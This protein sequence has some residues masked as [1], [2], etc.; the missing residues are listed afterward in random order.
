MSDANGAYSADIP[1]QELTAMDSLTERPRPP[2]VRRRE[3]PQLSCNACRSRNNYSSRGL[4]SSC[5]Y[6]TTGATLSGRPHGSAHVQE[7][8]N[9]LEN[10]VLSLMPSDILPVT[11]DEGP[12]CES[13]SLSGI[14]P[15]RP[16]AASPETQRE[17]S[18]SP[19]DYGS[20][21]IRESG[22]RYVSSEN[23]ATVLDSIAE[24][25][26]HFEHEDETYAHSPDPV[27]LQT[28]VPSP[29]L[30]YGCPS[31]VT[32][33]SILESI[34]PRS[35]VD[36]LVSRYFNDL[37]MATGKAPNLANAPKGSA[38][39]LLTDRRPGA[40][41][42]GKFLREYEEFWKN[43]QAVPIIWVGL[44]FAMMCLFDTFP[45]GFSCSCQYL[46][47]QRELYTTGAGL[48]EPNGDREG[49]PYALESLILYFLVEVFL[50]KEVE[51]GIWILV[52][53]IVQIAIHMGYHRDATH[54]P[55]ISPFADE[56]RR[57]VWAIIVQLDFSIA[58]QMGLPRLIKE[59]QTN[60]AEPRNLEDSDFDEL[61]ELPPSRPETEVTPTLYTLAKLRIISVG[62]N[63]ADVATELRP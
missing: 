24:L 59:S 10:L 40:L 49:A 60:T 20:I 27:Q 26:G 51:I 34:P 1:A 42:R 13:P 39:F 2:H 45:T 52:G 54:F 8:I 30:L 9:Q 32:L 17:V 18:P 41:H 15:K 4:G 61:T 55:N 14:D 56:M 22:V 28:N 37:D 48:R 35:V 36:R 38:I 5:T 44:L 46:A 16:L 62:V 31:Q 29:Q 3:K 6:S 33:D 11:P 12:P 47:C 58:T 50:L 19:S 7:R 57:R 21:R 53:S 43:P 63:T 25:R 23:W